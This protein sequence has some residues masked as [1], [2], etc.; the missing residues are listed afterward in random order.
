MKLLWLSALSCNGNVHSFFNYE[1]LEHFLEEFSFIYH[2]TI[3]SD[4]TLNDLYSKNIDCDILLLEGTLE[5]DLEKGD[6][7]FHTLLEKYGTK[8]KKIITV[9]TCASFGGIFAKGYP[10]RY[11]L[12]Y[13]EEALHTRY[14]SFKDKTINISG[15]PIHP[16][17]LASTL[18]SIKKEYYIKLDHYQRPKEYFG[19][20]THNGCLRNEYFEYKIDN[21]QFGNLEGCMFYDHGCQGPFTN[22][23]CNKVLWNEVSSKTRSGHPCVGCTEPLFP[24]ANLLST[25]KYMGIPAN[26]PLGVPKR[27]Y[28]SLAGVAKAFTIER[29][30]KK[31]I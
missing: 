3:E 15:C 20:T 8:A 25:K 5:D 28:L 18:Y 22:S 14:K 24:K 9:G 10:N 30:E 12:H 1:N 7:K 16:E 31:L 2:P 27:T 4:Y 13:K 17:T 23:S 19:F 11:G 6:G 29:F 26:L 21:H